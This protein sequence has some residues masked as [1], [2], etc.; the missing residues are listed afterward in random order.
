MSA[1]PRRRAGGAKGG[2]AKG[3]G[4]K[5]RVVVVFGGRSAEHEVSVASARSVMEALDQTGYH[6]YLTFEYFHPY[7]H[8]PEALVYQTSDSLDRLLGRK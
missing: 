6:G 5:R 7:L 2:G 4:P 1:A 3:G 8:Y